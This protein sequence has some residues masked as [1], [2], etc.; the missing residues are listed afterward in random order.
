MAT[1]K[2]GN[3]T[4]QERTPL[5]SQ[6]MADFNSAAERDVLKSGARTARGTGSQ[7]CVHIGHDGGICA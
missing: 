7:L 4:N 1:S 6:G 3:E 2:D 5:V